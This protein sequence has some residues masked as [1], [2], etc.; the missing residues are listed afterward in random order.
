VE[1]YLITF[2]LTQS[3]NELK[4]YQKPDQ[5]NVRVFSVYMQCL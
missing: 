3:Y 4:T 1:K 5:L 2:M